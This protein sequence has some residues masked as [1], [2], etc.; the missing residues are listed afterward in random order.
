[1]SVAGTGGDTQNPPT[2]T[3][4]NPLSI[5]T[6]ITLPDLTAGSFVPFWLQ[7]LIPANTANQ[8]NNTSELVV[9]VTSPT[10]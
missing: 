4:E 6:A 9:R 8:T 3:F 7:D 2:V 1:M 5:D 10:P